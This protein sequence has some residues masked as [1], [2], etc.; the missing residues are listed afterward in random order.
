L[1]FRDILQNTEK[2]RKKDLD[3][4]QI[5]FIRDRTKDINDKLYH[6]ILT[7]QIF[8]VTKK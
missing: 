6:Y 3:R 7:S 5:C 2:Y 8:E 4:A 1:I